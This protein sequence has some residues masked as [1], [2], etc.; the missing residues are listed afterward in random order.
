MSRPLRI[1][2]PDAC[3]HVTC[4]GNGK[5]NIFLTDHDRSKF[6][7]LLTRSVGIYDVRLYAFVLMANHFHL[8]VKTPGANLQEF[9]RHFNISYTAYFNKLHQR[10]GHLYQG[11]YKSFLI[12]VD[13]YFLEVSRY[14]HLNPV[15][16]PSFSESSDEEKKIALNA[17]M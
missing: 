13:S 10:S 3:Y 9:M 5:Q 7:E 17:Y 2:Y 1:Q 4:R 14:I 8:I 15:R 12:D 16:I 11:R 6:L